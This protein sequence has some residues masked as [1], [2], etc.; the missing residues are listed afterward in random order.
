MSLNIRKSS[1]VNT[2]GTRRETQQEDIEKET[3]SAKNRQPTTARLRSRNVN[4]ELSVRGKHTVQPNEKSSKSPSQKGTENR[5]GILI[6]WTR[7]KPKL[8]FIIIIMTFDVVNVAV[9]VPQ[10][11]RVRASV[12]STWS[13]RA[14]LS[15]ARLNLRDFLRSVAMMTLRRACCWPH[16]WSSSSHIKKMMEKN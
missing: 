5:I 14:P 6:E 10:S 9:I 15:H 4:V 8:S 16:E 7:T 11:A 1:R 13:P 3:T 12:G 2:H